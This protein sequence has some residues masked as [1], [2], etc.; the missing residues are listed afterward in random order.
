MLH[1][2]APTVIDLF[3]GCGGMS[4]GL[5][6][7]GFKPVLAVELNQSARATYLANRPGDLAPRVLEDVRALSQLPPAD[8]LQ[9]AGLRS[10][11]HPTLVTGGPPC[12]GFSGI[13]HRRTHSDIEKE[14]I[15]SNHLFRDM[16]EV[17][18]KV[19]PE[20]FIFE[21]VRG[22][23]SSR[24][25]RD[26]D[27]R[28]WD[29]V[30]EHYLGVL[31]GTYAIAYQLVR[32]YD[33]G[34]SQNRPRV[35]MVGVRRDRWEIKNFHGWSTDEVNLRTRSND[36]V[37]VRAGLLPPPI[38][39]TGFT[40]D[41]ID[42]LGDLVDASWDTRGTENG[43]RACLTYPHAAMT[44]WQR[45]MRVKDHAHADAARAEAPLEDQEYSNHSAHVRH[46]FS[47]ILKRKDRTAPK[48]LRTKKFAQRGIP[49]RWD[50]RPRIT[51]ASL[52]DDYV[53]FTHPRSLTVR[54]WA[55]LQGFPDWYM[56]RGPRTTGG[57]RRAGDVRRG[58][59]VRETPK[60]T[61]IGNAV[62]VPLAAALGM[63]L[64]RVLGRDENAAENGYSGTEYARFLRR[65]LDEAGRTRDSYR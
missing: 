1:E 3:A 15:A 49:P 19:R 18:R 64:L 42:L 22:L 20:A 46:R 50:G 17:I 37:A 43:R 4:L 32:A 41:P 45:V 58:D 8:I 60:Y 9:A 34:V 28:V 44:E 10:G 16:A 21:N 13:G 31:G 36:Q 23:L 40:P 6:L 47:Q 2:A 61:Q 7:V 62:P 25:T 55:R 53:H 63:H 59:S 14:E 54:E 30:R 56:F 33:Y 48:R 29:E 27:R 26:S 65:H 35:L 51:V 11:Q 52:P 5:E 24:W 39:V 57:A 38:D 12:Q